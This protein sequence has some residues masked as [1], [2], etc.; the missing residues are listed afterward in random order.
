[1]NTYGQNLIINP[2]AESDPTTSGWTLV[3]TG[4]TCYTGSNWRITGN[5]NGFPAALNGAY[6]FF[7]G[8]DFINGEI[9]QVVDL[10]AYAALIDAGSQSFTFSSYSQSFTQTPADGA[11]I[12]VEYR[13][14]S[15]AVL[16]FYDT[17]ITQN[18][19]VWTQYS[20]IRTAPVGTRSIRITL[21]SI[22]NSGGAVDGYIDDLSLTTNSPLPVE[23]INFTATL[24]KNNDV[25]LNWQTASEINNDFFSIERSNNG[26]DWEER[27]RIIGAG[28]SSTLLNYS[29]SDINPYSN[30]SYYRLKQTDFDGQFKYSEIISVNINT[31]TGTQVMVYPNP[32]ENQI[33]LVGSLSELEQV[34]IYNALGQDVTEFTKQ[35]ASDKSKLMIDLSSLNEGL[36]YIK[37]KTTANKVYKQ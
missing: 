32:T 2:S 20:D 35:I 3:T 10:A 29:A 31:D 25:K 24:S 15:L 28:N 33:T 5:Q 23:L 21:F 8:C 7:S 26:I 22:S 19:G 13:D 17:G 37:T 12:L 16:D 9:Y 1:M 11:R 36:Y 14:A 6:I 27:T 30:V 34:K 18:Q 4:T